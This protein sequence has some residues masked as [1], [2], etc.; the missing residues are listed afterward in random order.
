MTT[1]SFRERLRE[2]PFRPFRL[3]MADGRSLDVPH[4]GMAFLTTTSVVVGTD[5]GDDGIPYG[6][7]VRPL[8]HIQAVE[9]IAIGG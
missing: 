9:P 8:P 3:L 2:R 6:F 5:P 7:K 4:P 1:P